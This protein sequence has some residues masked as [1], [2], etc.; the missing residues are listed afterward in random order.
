M[1]KIKGK[2]NGII[3]CIGKQWYPRTLSNQ[4]S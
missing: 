4:S 1:L 3:D 2:K